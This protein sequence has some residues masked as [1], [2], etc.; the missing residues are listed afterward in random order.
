M[1]EAAAIEIAERRALRRQV[2]GYQPPRNAA[3]QNMEDPVQDLAHRTDRRPT[4]AGGI[5]QERLDDRPL[6]IRQIGFISQASAAIMPP[7][8]GVHMALPGQ[9]SAPSWN[10]LDPRPLNP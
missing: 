2:L 1:T 5:G 3:T 10:H 4:A 9:A 7:V 8:V 6:G